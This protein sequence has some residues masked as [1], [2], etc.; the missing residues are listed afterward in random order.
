M[1][2]QSKGTYGSIFAARHEALEMVR[3]KQKKGYVNIEDVNYS[4]P[5]TMG[6]PD[7]VKYLEGGA[8]ASPE[9]VEPP[10]PKAKPRKKR[11]RK[12]E[13]PEL[14]GDQVC[15]AECVGNE[16]MEEYFDLGVDYIVERLEESSRGEKIIVMLDLT[17]SER[18]CYRDRFGKLRVE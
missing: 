18:L 16:G 13:M 17:G 4:G 10:K 6:S 5:L 8:V 9:P 7:V 14:S 11:S 1:S 12:E 15:V 3:S 2:E